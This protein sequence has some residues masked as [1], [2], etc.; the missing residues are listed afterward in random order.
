MSQHSSQ[1]G[2]IVLLTLPFCPIQAFNWLDEAHPYKGWQ[3]ALPSTDSN[4]SLT[5][6]YPHRHTRIMFGQMSESES[7]SDMI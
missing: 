4:V 2:E 7:G 3:S 6:K 1:T 5:Q